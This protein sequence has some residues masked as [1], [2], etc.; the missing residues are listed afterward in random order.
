MT[1]PALPPF[2]YGTFDWRGNGYFLDSDPGFDLL[3]DRVLADANPWIVLAAVLERAK[4]GAHADAIVLTSFFER[5]EPFALARTSLLLFADVAPVSKLGMLESWLRGDDALARVYAAEAAAVSGALALVPAMLDAWQRAATINDHEC[6]GFD[7]SSVLE[8][9]VGEI[10]EAVGIYDS[11]LPP[12]G[13][14]AGLDRLRASRLA[15]DPEASPPP[16]P[17]LVLAAFARLQGRLGPNSFAWNG[18]IADIRRLAGK[19]LDAARDPEAGPGRFLDL[20]HRFEATT[21][22]DCREFFKK[23]AAQ[24]LRIAATTE[25]FLRS[26]AAALFEPGVRYFF[27]HRIPD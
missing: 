1:Q 8:D 19:L 23:G 13:V 20:R 21:G 10:G 25:D 18:A 11:P 24:R 22:V 27:G 12:A 7:L 14:S 4:R 16:L 17:D 2:L 6:V 3:S 5:R 26:P 15:Q 9:G